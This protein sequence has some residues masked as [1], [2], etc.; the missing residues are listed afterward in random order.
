MSRAVHRRPA[1][2]PLHAGTWVQD[3]RRCEF[4]DATLAFFRTAAGGPYDCL[5]EAAGAPLEWAPALSCMEGAGA[6][7][8]EA[9]PPACRVRDGAEYRMGWMQARPDGTSGAC[10]YPTAAGTGAAATLARTGGPLG[11]EVLC[12][13]GARSWGVQGH[14][15][16]GC[17]ALS[18]SACLPHPITQ[19][20]RVCRGM[21]FT[22]V[23]TAA[24]SSALPAGWCLLRGCGG[25]SG[26]SRLARLPAGPAAPCRCVH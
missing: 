24:P 19:C 13:S 3:N 4:A 8:R 16:G 12:R 22:Q 18:G 11:A 15:A 26:G 1:P 9:A 2:L 7:I 5:C 6:A 23:G 10:I 20:A 25:G 21:Y 17:S 14:A